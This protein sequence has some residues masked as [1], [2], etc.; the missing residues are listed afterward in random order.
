MNVFIY[1]F[2]RS[3]RLCNFLPRF[4]KD[5][6][7]QKIAL[8]SPNQELACVDYLQHRI[9]GTLPAINGVETVTK[10]IR[11]K[12]SDDP[13]LQFQIFMFPSVLELA[14]VLGSSYSMCQTIS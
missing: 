2:Y 6:P 10:N 7:Q 4:L 11:R 1:L 14:I 12:Q 9:E 13:V 3:N 5:L 8:R